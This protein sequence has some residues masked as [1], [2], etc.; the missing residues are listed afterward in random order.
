MPPPVE[1]QPLPPNWVN[2]PGLDHAV[3]I[4]G[5]GQTGMAVSR[6]LRKAGIGEVVLLDRDGPEQVGAWSTIARMLTLRTERDITGPEIWE[7]ELSFRHW[8]VARHGEVAYEAI[9]FIPLDDWIAYLHW[10]RSET[11]PNISFG[12][13]FKGVRRGEGGTLLVDIET[14]EG[15]R[16]LTTDHLVVAS[17]MDGFGDKYVP[18]SLSAGAPEGHLFHT[19]DAVPYGDMVERRVLVVGGAS[20]AFDAASTA[21]EHGA[22]YVDQI[23]RGQQLAP[24]VPRGGL[25]FVNTERRFFCELSDESRWSWVTR[26]R[27]HGN[28]PRHSV[29]RPRC[30]KNYQMYLGQPATGLVWAGEVAR[31]R[32]GGQIRE[33]DIVIAATGYHQGAHLRE[34]F[35]EIVPL[36]KTWGDV[37]GTMTEENRHWGGLPYLGRGFGLTPRD[38]KEDWVSRIHVMTFAALL[39]HGV[40]VGDIGST[41]LTVP[42]LVEAIARDFFEK[43]RAEIEQRFRS[44]THVTTR[45]VGEVA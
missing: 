20:S 10:F 11:Q 34:E 39:S 40:H 4:V 32:V 2:R 30:F 1:P 15:R 8:Y 31:L 9:D 19:Q 23:V 5:G 6:A 43:Q 18:E 35:R 24:D 42:R 21:L 13:T 16:S 44:G 45:K 26:A 3:V 28:A 37:I 27:A 25:R 33:Y 41:S 38:P 17:G 14:A 36:V 22:L 29:V 7:K 12:T